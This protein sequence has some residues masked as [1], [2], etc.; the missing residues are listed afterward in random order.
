VEA[1]SEADIYFVYLNNAFNSP[2]F[3]TPNESMI[4]EK[5]VEGSLIAQFEVISEH[6]FLV[7]LRTTTEIF[8][9]N[10][11]SLNW[12]LNSSCASEI[13]NATQSTAAFFPM[14][15]MA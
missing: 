11:R 15:Y 10:R 13:G 14:V 9:Q 7:G 4:R 12:N 6:F 8:S 5:C 3:I 2:E 1:V